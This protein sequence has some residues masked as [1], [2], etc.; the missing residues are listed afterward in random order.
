MSLFN[1]PHPGS[2]ILEYVIDHGDSVAALAQRLDIDVLELTNVVDGCCAI[3]PEMAQRLE[4]A[5]G[6]SA[7]L[8][9]RM[10]D[11]YDAAHC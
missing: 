2:L 8:W 9:L 3:S 11:A 5:L 6:L 1:P 7:D 4:A 10:Q